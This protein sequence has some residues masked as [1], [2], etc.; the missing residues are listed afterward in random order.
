MCI[1]NKVL[2]TSSPFNVSSAIRLK[3]CYRPVYIDNGQKITKEEL[4]TSLIVHLPEVII[5]GTEYY[6]K[7][8]LD[9]CK[10]LKL[11]SRV[12]AGLDSID[13]EECKKRE[14]VVTHVPDAPSNAVAELTICQMINLLRRV[15]MV[16]RHLYKGYWDRYIGRELKNC[17][18]GIIGHGRIGTLVSHKL[19]YGFRIQN[20]DLYINDILMEDFC[21]SKEEILKECDIVTLHIPYNEDNHYFIDEK[22]F[23]IMG[24][25]K[26]LINTSRGGIVNEY[27][28]FNWL[29]DESNSAAVDTFIAEPYCGKLCSLPNV[30]LTPHLGS[31]TVQSRKDME[32][33]AVQEVLNYFNGKDY[34]H[35]VI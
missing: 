23:D 32:E 29:Q 19:H 20:D 28:L 18:V 26:I 10:N 17:K 8:V 33:G 5:A 6:D 31:C 13:L 16:D 1:K 22:E 30:I 21:S 7:E 9:Y 14:I 25:N 12:G 3:H 11:I 34:N 35:R 2:V 15:P 4:I 27:A 24:S